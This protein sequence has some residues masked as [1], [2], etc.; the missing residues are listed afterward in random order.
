[1]KIATVLATAASA[2]AFVA[3]PGVQAHGGMIDP[4]PRALT[5]MGLAIDST[6]GHPIT[7]RGDYTNGKG[8]DCLGFTPDT[9]LKALPFG[10]T[11]IKMRANDGANHVG[12]C[13]MYLVDPQDK[14]NKLQVGQMN[15][16]MRSLHPGP[17]NKGDQ[18]IPAEMKINVPSG[19]SL[20]CR[21]GHCVLEFAWEAR[22][23][24]PYEHY[25]N[26]ADVKVGSS[27]DSSSNTTPAPATTKAPSTTKTP[28]VTK[29]PT[30][31][32]PATKAPTQ[33]TAKPSTSTGSGGKY[34]YIH[35]TAD[36]PALTQWCNWNCPQFCPEDMC[37]LA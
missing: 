24:T 28:A 36:E 34:K 37:A 30:P 11:T 18:P 9:N 3:T 20:P 15:D 8:G 14:S 2:I 16:C 27:G 23:I 32:K 21:N 6:F 22:H 17:G 33:T 5:T 19:A 13:T 25:N 10:E 31:T 26:C 7:M 4:K 29:T 1:M 35:N 12:P